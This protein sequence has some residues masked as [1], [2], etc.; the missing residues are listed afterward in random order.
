MKLNYIKLTGIIGTILM[1]LCVFPY[2][3]GFFLLIGIILAFI[4]LNEFADYYNNRRIFNYAIYAFI[5]QIIGVVITSIVIVYGASDFLTSLGI[6]SPADLGNLQ[7]I[8][9]KY[10]INTSNLAPFLEI[11]T[12]GLLVIFAFSIASGI[13]FRKSMNML[14][15]RSGNGLYHTTGTLVFIGAFLTIIFIGFII[16]WISFIL[17]AFS[18]LKNKPLE[19]SIQ[20]PLETITVHNNNF[21]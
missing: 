11:I 9:W 20:N 7:N 17:L 4:A 8:N 3:G 16:I 10:A 2:A 1:I 18:F 21:F 6:S 5:L 19:K 13:Y 14:G 15:E 12:I